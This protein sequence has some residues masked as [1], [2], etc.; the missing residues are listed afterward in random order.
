MYIHGHFCAEYDPKE[1]FIT[2]LLAAHSKGEI[3]KWNREARREMISK[4]DVI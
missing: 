1:Y 3:E 2:V 4:R